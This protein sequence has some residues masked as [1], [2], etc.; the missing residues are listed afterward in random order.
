M[1]TAEWSFH[2]SLICGF[3][4]RPAT[5]QDFTNVSMW[6]TLW[7]VIQ[8]QLNWVWNFE[9]A[10]RDNYFLIWKTLSTGQLWGTRY[11]SGLLVNKTTISWSGRRTPPQ[12][13]NCGA[14]WQD[15]RRSGL[16]RPSR[17]QTPG[18][19][20]SEVIV[21]FIF[22]RL[23]VNLHHEIGEAVDDGDA[24]GA[25]YR[26]RVCVHHPERLH[27]PLDPEYLII[28]QIIIEAIL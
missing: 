11:W 13:G 10:Q 5:L 1:S 14:T 26:L 18:G 16:P 25:F 22:L 28:G 19:I 15:Q 17:G 12:L 3:A 21:D 8:L 9:Q 27:N 4:V 6:S 23:I 2:F 7:W 20:T 24:L